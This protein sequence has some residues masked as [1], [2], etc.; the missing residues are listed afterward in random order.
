VAPT[1]AGP[2]PT[3]KPAPIRTALPAPTPEV[4]V[5]SS[6]TISIAGLQSIAVRTVGTTTGPVNVIELQT[7]GSTITGLDVL[8]PCSGHVQITTSAGRLAASSGLTIDATAL[9]A[10]IL[11][12]S[13][14]IAAAD[15]PAGPLTLPGISLPPLPTD[16]GLVSVKLFV[17]SLTSGSTSFGG[18]KITEAAC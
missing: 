1:A 8:G 14:T 12:I 13:I 3:P 18:L 5:L 6:D 7:A 17:L 16:L 2:A 4:S 9:Q 11:G 10:T 15:L